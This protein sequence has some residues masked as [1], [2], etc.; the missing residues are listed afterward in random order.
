MLE[1][2]PCPGTGEI[3]VA[4]SYRR[5]PVHPDRHALLVGGHFLVD[6]DALLE[7][8]EHG[9]GRHEGEHRVQGDAEDVQ[10]WM[11]EG[12]HRDT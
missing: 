12:G 2:R 3:T 7:E 1:Q 10:L 9:H 8:D 4:P 11:W 6:V 5:R